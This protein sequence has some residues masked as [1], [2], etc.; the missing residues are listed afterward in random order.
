MRSTTVRITRTDS[1]DRSV[2]LTIRYTPGTPDRGPDFNC[3]GGYPGD[4]ECIELV[5]SSVIDRGCDT[6]EVLRDWDGICE[7]ARE[8][9]ADREEAAEADWADYEHD[10][11]RDEA[12]GF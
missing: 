6:A 10:R 12:R 1:E 3:A 5:H 2:R 11:L 7:A 9:V 8:A 4:E